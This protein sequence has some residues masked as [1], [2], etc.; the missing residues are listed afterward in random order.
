MK[1][2]PKRQSDG[3]F[4]KGTS[5]NPKGRPKSEL[6]ALRKQIVPEAQA[7]LQQVVDKA[8]DGDLTAAK[9]ILDRV[10]PP[11]KPVSAPVTGHIDQ[12]KTL[13]GQAQAILTAASSGE[14][15]S[16]IAAQLIQAVANLCRIVETEELKDR[17]QAIEAAIQPK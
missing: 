15:S 5:G 2:K 3:T 10:L 17:I 9:L 16:D 7:I 12:A 4:A 13:A 1:S 11:L 6:A 8:L 14:V